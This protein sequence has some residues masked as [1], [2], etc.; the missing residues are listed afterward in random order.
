MAGKNNGKRADTPTAYN[1]RKTKPVK[2]TYKA[3]VRY[4]LDQS[5]KAAIAKAEETR[6]G[7]VDDLI[8]LSASGY[9]VSFGWDYVSDCYYLSL[10]CEAPDHPNAGLLLGARHESLQRAAATLWTLHN[11]VYQGVWPTDNAADV[12]W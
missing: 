11:E 8:D 5:L 10:L 3:S 9:K 7:M 1:P 6:K 12:N 2:A 4:V